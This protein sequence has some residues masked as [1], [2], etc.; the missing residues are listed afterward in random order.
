MADRPRKARSIRRK[1]RPKVFMGNT[2]KSSEASPSPVAVSTAS[3]KK[4]ALES[5]PTPSVSSEFDD[6]QGEDFHLIRV[7]SLQRAASAF[8]CCDTPLKVVEDRSSRRGLVSKLAIVC[9]VCGKSSTISDPYCQED[10]ATNTRSVLAARAIGKGRTALETFCSLMGLSAPTTAPA[11]S[12]H[13]KKLEA[14]CQRERECSFAAAAAELRKDAAEDEVVDIQVTCDGTWA[15]RGFQ[16]LYGVVVVASWTTG[17]VLDVE[18]LSKYCQVCASHSEMDESSE[19]FLDWWEGHQAFCQA[20]Y[21]G[22]SGAMESTGAISIWQRSVSKHKLRYTEMISDGDSKTFTNLA[23]L[24]PY[25]ESHPISKHECVGHV[26]KRMGTALR[27]LAN[28][29]ITDENGDRVRMKGK[30]RLTANTIKLL[31]KYYGKAIRSNI[32]DP[33]KMKEAVMAIYHHSRSTDSDPHHHLCSTGRTSWC[34]YNRALALAEPPPPHNT[35]IHP[36]I[37][38]YV[39]PV[40]ERLSED[41]LMQRCHLGAT[42]NQNESFNATIWNY[43]PKNEFCSTSTV[44]VAVS[45]AAITFNDGRL[46]FVKLQEQL[47]VKVTPNTRNYLQAKDTRRVSGAQYKAQDLVR[48]RRQALHLD[49]VSL[50][51]QQIEEEGVTYGAGEF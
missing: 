4:L 17:K 50:E 27:K 38:K 36:E 42:Q 25:G 15:R 44:E 5:R 14:V 46:P 9:E 47:G 16:S 1:K 43:C 49:R 28:E 19:E 35:T 10:L 6:E 12:V 23:E 7:G 22:S 3:K 21:V 29:K 40:F 18:V 51:E 45:L 33:V 20:N 32:G 8:S 48:K 34:K 41:T 24:K 2:T 11:F 39:L 31:T 13:N 26:Q 37:A 30:G